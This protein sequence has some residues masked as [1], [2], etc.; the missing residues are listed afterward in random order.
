MNIFI[1]INTRIFPPNI[2]AYYKFLASFYCYIFIGKL[3]EYIFKRC[4][5]T[6]N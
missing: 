2:K 3:N 6:V 1:Q 5:I 4:N